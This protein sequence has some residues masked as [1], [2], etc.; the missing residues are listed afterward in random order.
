M[1]HIET[2]TKECKVC[3]RELTLDRFELMNPHSEKP[4][5]LGT[6]KSCRYQYMRKR[7]EEKKEVKLADNIKILVHRAYKK[8]NPE[9][10][11]DLSLTNIK[12]LAADEMFVKL[13]DYKDIWLS[14]YG[15]VARY[16]HES[17]EY[18]L[19]KGSETSE[20]AVKYSVL[21]NVY[22]DGEWVYKQAYL[23]AAHAVVRE[24][25]VNPDTVNNVFI[26]HK[27]NNKKDN[28]YKNL[29]PLNR[30]QYY[31]LRRYYNKN[32]DDAEEIIVKIM[33][34]MRYKLDDWS[35]RSMR[36]TMCGIGYH[37]KEDVD[38]TSIIYIR[39]HD[40]LSRC[41]NDKFH[42]RQP[43]YTNCTVCEEWLNFCNFEK[44]YKEHYYETEDNSMDLD[45]DILF[46][47][48]KEYSP[49]TCCI[50]PHSIN[51]LFLTGKKS[52]GDLPLGVWF[53]RSKNKYRVGMCYK[54]IHI[55]IGT[56]KSVDDAFSRYKVY[57]EDFIKDIAEQHKGL[58]PDKVYQ[59]M[60]NWQIEITD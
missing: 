6:C 46:K 55:K 14:N 9:R 53:D 47:G 22:V 49:A 44:W 16:I 30:D 15:R 59:A 60:M 54:G 34:T 43:Q 3:G 10:I 56:F 7:I 13:M 2:E 21:K 33:N 58:I 37:G 4:Y 35:E 17:K 1:N 12:P 11:L 41:Y 32:K 18:K 31:A 5:Y 27:G 24:F 48:N 36:P 42:E 8:I 39:W 20:G 51:T 38:C 29:Y 19:L 50:V 57:K 52:K 40:M 25:V 26:W 28:Y 45:K 23:Y